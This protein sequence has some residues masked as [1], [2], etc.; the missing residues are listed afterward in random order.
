MLDKQIADKKRE[1]NRKANHYHKRKPDNMPP[2]KRF[3][4]DKFNN[5]D[6]IYQ[7]WQS[8]DANQ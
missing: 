8:E 1:K 3:K 2:Q 5:F 7:L 6:E 4:Q